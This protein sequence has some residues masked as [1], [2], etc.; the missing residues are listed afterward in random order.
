MVKNSGLYL[1]NGLPIMEK[2]RSEEGSKA[3]P[4]G[5]K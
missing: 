1:L 2:Q 3:V 5:T 4:E